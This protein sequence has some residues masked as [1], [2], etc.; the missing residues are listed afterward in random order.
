MT[1]KLW[2]SIEPSKNQT[3]EWRK[4]QPWYLNGKHNECGQYQK[5]IIEGITK[6]T[7]NKA[8]RLRGLKRFNE[9]PENN[10]KNNLLQF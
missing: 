5:R 7:I 3:K 8:H 9:C 4:S 10:G 2:K 6:A 1:S